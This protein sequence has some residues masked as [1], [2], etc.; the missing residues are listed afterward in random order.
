MNITRRQVTSQDDAFLLA[1]FKAVRAPDFAIAGLAPAQLDMLLD[2]QFQAQTGGYA[3]QFPGADNQIVLLDGVDAG[4]ILVHR[5]PSQ[6]V[7]VDISVLP[8]HQNRGLG[9]ALVTG[10]IAE[11]RAAGVPLRCSVGLSNT[12]SLRFHQRLGFRIVSQDAVY[13]ELEYIS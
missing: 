9:T 11:A 8:A 13:C 1:L 4:R 10:L 3:A 2:M 6:F 12:G 5:S 7:L